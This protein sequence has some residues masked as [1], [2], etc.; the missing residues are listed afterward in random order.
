[1]YENGENV[2]CVTDEDVAEYVDREPDRWVLAEEHGWV[3]YNRV[4][5]IDIEEDLLGN[6]WV[7]FQY[8]GRLY[9]SNIVI[10]SRPE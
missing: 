4:G 3:N 2:L 8:K 9:E 5:F 7:I 6:D 1:M 10:G